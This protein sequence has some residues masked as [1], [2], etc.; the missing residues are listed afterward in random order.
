MGKTRTKCDQIIRECFSKVAQVV[1]QSRVPFPPLDPTQRRSSKWFNLELD[2]LDIVS[3]LSQW[4]TNI[5]QPLFIDIYFEIR[6]SPLTQTPNANN[7][8]TPLMER[9]KLCYDPS[10][11]SNKSIELA[12]LYKHLSLMIRSLYGTLR[13]MPAYKVFRSLLRNKMSGCAI[14]FAF[15]KAEMPDPVFAQKSRSEFKWGTVYSPF[16]VLSLGV[17][18][19]DDCSYEATCATKISLLSDPLIIKDYVSSDQMQTGGMNSS[20]SSIPIPVSRTRSA[21]EIVGVESDNYGKSAPIGIPSRGQRH[22]LYDESPLSP[23]QITG[24]SPSPKYSTS[25]PSQS[26]SFPTYTQNF[27]NPGFTSN[28]GNSVPTNYGNFMANEGIGNSSRSR[29]TSFS[30]SSLI[31]QNTSNNLNNVNQNNANLSFNTVL[32]TTPPFP[33]SSSPSTQIAFNRQP[34]NPSLF[35]SSNSAHSGQM[36]SGS[37]APYK[38]SISL[39]KEQPSEQQQQ[40]HPSHTQQKPFP[41]A[42]TSALLDPVDSSIMAAS[43]YP[44]N[45]TSSVPV[46]ALFSIPKNDE[47]AFVIGESL[48]VDGEIGEFIRMCQTAAPLR[49]FEGKKKKLQVDELLREEFDLTEL[50]KIEAVE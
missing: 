2:D 45:L 16:G 50:K 6:N 42:K 15:R 25:V 35:G 28:Y 21:S 14:K 17:M 43:S 44:L 24:F 34:S 38:L 1:L 7:N 23:G 18:F 47:P 12:T 13:L 27:S 33:I 37:T 40:Q 3:E 31:T 10:S 30:P 20:P 19:R 26:P 22:P 41:N 5:Y 39:F 46:D 48:N 8:Y 11:V 9:W 36:S 49:M 29:A 32:S 4:R